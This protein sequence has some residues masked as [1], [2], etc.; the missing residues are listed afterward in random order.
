M[1]GVHHADTQA[2]YLAQEGRM[3]THGGKGCEV[4][5]SCFFTILYM[6][7]A[8]WAKRL[9][10]GGLLGALWLAYVDFNA[11]FLQPLD[12]TET[13][14]GLPATGWELYEK[15]LQLVRSVPHLEQVLVGIYVYGYVLSITLAVVYGLL[16]GRPD[17]TDGAVMGFA[18][19][20]AIAGTAYAFAYVHPP[21]TVYGVN[22]VRSRYMELANNRFVFPS[23]HAAFATFLAL[24]FWRRARHRTVRW[25]Y[26]FLGVITPVNIVVLVQHWVYDA[27][28][29]I[30]LGVLAFLA[31]ERWGSK[32]SRAV[33]RWN[34]AEKRVWAATVMIYAVLLIY[35]TV[36]MGLLPLSPWPPGTGGSARGYL[37]IFKK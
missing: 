2:D 31:V 20:L 23:L 26:A 16:T 15:L 19:M 8:E 3:E 14:R 24:Y 32:F 11:L 36:K 27:I 25:A 13:M 18:L 6:V 1:G 5:K 34:V 37:E 33:D 17:V 7:D 29:G 4:I 22:P 35:S 21:H 9:F 10:L 12:W 30:L 28:A